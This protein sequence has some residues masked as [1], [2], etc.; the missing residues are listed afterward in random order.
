M[1]AFERSGQRLFSS[2]DYDAFSH[3]LPELCLSGPKLFTVTTNDQRCLLFALLLPDVC[4]DFHFF[5]LACHLNTPPA[6]HG[7]P[8]DEQQEVVHTQNP[9]GKPLL[10]GSIDLSKLSRSVFQ[11][12]N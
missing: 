12:P 3:P 8:V 5:D 6:L 7:F 9:V 1:L 4:Y 11:R 10:R 2:F